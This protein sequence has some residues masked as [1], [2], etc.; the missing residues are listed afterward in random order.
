MKVR[1]IVGKHLHRQDSHPRVTGDLVFGADLHL[2]GLLYSKVLRSSQ[3]NAEI[4]AIDIS[5]AVAH[6]RVRAALTA[7]DLARILL[8]NTVNRRK[9]PAPPEC[10]RMIFGIYNGQSNSQTLFKK[11]AHMFT[12]F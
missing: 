8:P 3:A 11:E 5:R 6:P 9:S 4:L 2:P 7:A 10:K 12:V 1:R